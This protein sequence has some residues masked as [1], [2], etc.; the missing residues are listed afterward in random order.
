MFT[1]LAML[2]V[3]LRSTVLKVHYRR[4]TIDST[5]RLKH[6]AEEVLYE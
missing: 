1:E 2:K 4:L 6:I 5:H 3:M